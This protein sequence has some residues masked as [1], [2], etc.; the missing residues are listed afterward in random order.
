MQ[1]IQNVGLQEYASPE[2]SEEITRF[3]VVVYGDDDNLFIARLYG[4]KPCIDLETLK[5]DRI[6]LEH[7]YPRFD[8]LSLSLAPHPL[9]DNVFFKLPN[10]YSYMGCN[11]KGERNDSIS[12]VLL[13]EANVCQLLSRSPHRNVAEY[14]GCQVQGGR[15][16]ALCFKKYTSTLEYRIK[17]ECKLDKDQVLEDIRMG[18]EHIHS[19]G[20]CHNDINPC[21]IMFDSDGKVVIIDFDSCRPS[22][23][24]LGVKK[25]TWG[26]FPAGETMSRPD[27]DF[28][29]LQMIEKYLGKASEEDSIDDDDSIDG[30]SVKSSS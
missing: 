10:L 17:H 3:T 15:I 27:N 22:G 21:N 1:I 14:L 25:G 4:R 8:A 6:P 23:E 30:Q 18:I 5:G 2:E 24:K 28:F 19:L 26:Y 12:K 20:Y 13:Q 29:G 16:V 7:V 9:P 11:G